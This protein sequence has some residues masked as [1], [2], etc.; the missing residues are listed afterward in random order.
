MENQL[1]NT[2]LNIILRLFAGLFFM[3]GIGCFRWSDVQRSKALNLTSDAI[4]GVAW[5]MKKKK[6][7]AVPWAVNRFSFSGRDWGGL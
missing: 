1:F 2:D 5:K 3:M 4:M 6:K 7:G